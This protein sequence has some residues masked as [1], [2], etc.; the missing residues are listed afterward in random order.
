[1]DIPDG[2]L[3]PR[4]HLET[5]VADGIWPSTLEGWRKPLLHD[6]LMAYLPA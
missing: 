3:C 2:L 5:L 6:A 4:R 1:L